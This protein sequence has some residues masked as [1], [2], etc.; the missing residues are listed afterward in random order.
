MELTLSDV[1]AELSAGSRVLLLVRHSERPKI[2]FDDKT[3]GA[4]LPLTTHGGGLCLEYGKLLA[5][6][7]EDVQ[8]RASPLRRTVMT[9][10]L[11][12]EGMGLKG[13]PVPTDSAIGNDS[14]FVVDASEVWRLF[15][16]GEF[17]RHMA[18]YLATGEARG[19]A[20][21]AAAAAAYESYAL[22]VFSGRLGVFT[23]HDVYIAAYLHA[24]GVKTDFNRGN[25]PR[26]LD[27][28]AIVIRPDGTL[29]RALVRA[30]LSPL[31][32]GV[33]P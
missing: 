19:F 14:A 22:S 9:A 8:F 32:C 29:V 7:A 3:F 13:A 24:K 6:A 23:T 20:P 26:F 21:L 16:D 18:E 17:F 28:A 33:A 4:A 11:V 30:G 1:R 5:G 10:E 27:A 15:S 12:A 2:D 25:W 31:V